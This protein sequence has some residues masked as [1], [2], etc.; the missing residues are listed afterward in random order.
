MNYTI[1]EIY[2]LVGKDDK[3]AGVTFR[4]ETESHNIYGEH[5]TLVFSYTQK[6]REMMDEMIKTE[7][8]KHHDYVQARY[9]GSDL[10]EDKIVRLKE[11]GL[12]SADILEILYLNLP[13]KNT[14]HSSE[15]RS[16]HK[17]NIPFPSSTKGKD[18]DWIWG[19]S[20][21]QVNENIGLSPNER[22]FYLAGKL[23]YE[24][25]EISD[26]E[27]EEIYQEDG[28]TLDIKIEWEL[29]QIKHMREEINEEEKIRLTELYSLKKKES[30]EILDKY[31]KDAG[32]SLKKLIADNIDQ[33]AN[34][35]MKVMHF[36]ERSLTIFSKHPVY[37]NLD[38]Y[39]HI[40]MR[41]VEEFKVSEHFENKDNFQWEEDD[42][43]SVMNSVIK[44]IEKEYEDFREKNPNNR[45]SRFGTQSFYYEGDY[46]TFHIETDGRISTFYKNKKNKKE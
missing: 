26:L 32:S 20:K 11:K 39:L 19:F 31:L 44:S 8:W 23:F 15:K 35:F 2:A 3:T 33:A 36:K 22:S 25:D 18:F 41:H 27:K 12:Y 10:E 14:F 46:Y 16:I 21:K 17:L 29:L 9:L 42:V 24:P 30:Y 38:S 6:Q 5:I 40:Y 7:P 45:Y 43:Y 28:T 1:E 13:T 37:I 34:L 4:R